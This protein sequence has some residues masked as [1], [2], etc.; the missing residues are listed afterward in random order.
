MVRMGSIEGSR[1][2]H[3]APA[4]VCV[5]LVCSAGAVTAE[6]T[7]KVA[8]A[9]VK[10]PVEKA[11]AD[12]PDESVSAALARL[13]KEAYA[14]EAGAQ[15]R[16]ALAELASL[17]ELTGDIEGAASAW[18]DAAF[19]AGE[20]RDDDA[21]LEAARCL[22]A[23]GELDRA[24]ADLRTVL[25]TGRNADAVARARYLGAQIA[26]FRADADAVAT[27]GAF[28]DDPAYA[29]RRPATLYLLWRAGAD[30]SFRARLIAEHGASPEAALAAA[31][32]SVS[33]APTPL[34]LFFPARAEA[35][36]PL[37]AAKESAA[38]ESA[39]K[40]SAPQ[41]SAPQASAAP[42]A[43]A[44]AAAPVAS[45]PIAAS[46][47]AGSGT[48]E[49]AAR[50]AAAPGGAPAGGQV[51]LQIGLFKR[52]ENARALMKRLE[53]AGFKAA[54]VP[55]AVGKDEY[56]AVTVSGGLRPD[57]TAIRLRDAGFESFPLY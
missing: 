12:A 55:R 5:A 54:L 33:A 48:A 25:I 27:L 7:R 13:A 18:A 56:L 41:A 22:I 21:L 1:R 26:V 10:P 36:P 24:F 37:A 44:P 35:F 52:E 38:K 32:A 29:D 40:E 57:E 23:L 43:A 17:R 45:A 42:V 16:S 53:A 51:I 11:T 20:G 34:W 47:A 3:L 6:E 30:E 50:P 19:A 9:A 46:S 14:L 49:T 4:L 28:V 8:P 15:R 39:A 2:F 31:S